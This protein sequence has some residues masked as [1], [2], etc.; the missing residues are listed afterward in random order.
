MVNV[1]GQATSSL[2]TVVMVSLVSDLAEHVTTGIVELL[3]VFA[4]VFVFVFE[5]Q[6][7]WQ[8]WLLWWQW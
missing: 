7:L 2:M 3:S 1:T 8:S 4:F 5:S 6:P